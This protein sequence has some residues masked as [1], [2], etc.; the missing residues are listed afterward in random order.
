MEN[1]FWKFSIHKEIFALK[2]DCANFLESIKENFVDWK[3]IRWT[4]SEKTGIA[5]ERFENK[6]FKYKIFSFCV[7]RF[8][9]SCCSLSTAFGYKDRTLLELGIDYAVKRYSQ[10]AISQ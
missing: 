9:F 10:K 5:E 7:L 1:I 3:I 2:A 6:N 8:K 4:D